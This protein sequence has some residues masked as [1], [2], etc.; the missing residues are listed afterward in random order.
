MAEVEA[1]LNSR[2]INHVSDN[3]SD[4]E[5]LTPNHFLLRRGCPNMPLNVFVDR[6]VSS[7]K[8][9]RQTQV[10]TDQIWKRG[11]KELYLHP[12]RNLQVGDVVLIAEKTARGHWPLG[13]VTMVYPG[14]DGVVRTV[15][16]KTAQGTFR[17]P[18]T[19]IAVIEE[20]SSENWWTLG[21]AVRTDGSLLK[22]LVVL[23][24]HSNHV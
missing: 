1:Q 14:S 2:T 23:W 21:P 24:Y 15:E 3:I 5:A 10:L 16:V 19:R 22:E 9:W 12:I 20:C 8:R 17:R 11:T 18:A 6:K 13:K 7:R 4:P